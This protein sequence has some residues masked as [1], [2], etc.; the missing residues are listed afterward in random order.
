MDSVRTPKHFIQSLARGLKVLQAFSADKPRL[1]L[2]QLAKITGYNKTAVQRLTDTLMSLGF[3][4]RNEYKEFYLEPKVLSLG[5]A[6]LN[7]SELRQLAETHLKEFGERVNCTVNL[8]VLDGTQVVILYRHEV[9]TFFNF[10]LVAGSKL[11]AYCT[12]MGKVLL[13]G[14]ELDELVRRVERMELLPLTSYTITDQ[15]RF[16]EEIKLTR[17]RGYAV[18]D[19]E[20]T[21]ALSSLAVPLMDRN[22]HTAATVNLS[23]DA[24]E[25]RGK[26]M[27]PLIKALLDEGER[28][29]RLMGFDGVYRRAP[30]G[31]LHA[32]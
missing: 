9:Q 15:D 6:Y 32:G 4:G 18:C 26:D 3:L 30:E 14:L 7:G 13:A 28:L 1:G 29:S 8:A 17:E 11:P 5:F 10:A 22:G 24:E 12:A 25:V 20:G 16:L 2:Q 31:G 19:R 21:L 23:L 27:D